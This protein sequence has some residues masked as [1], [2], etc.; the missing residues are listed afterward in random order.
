MIFKIC[1]LKNKESVI[2]CEKN[3]VDLFGMIF[4]EKSPRNISFKQA[5][6]LVNL[7]SDLKIKPVGV[8]V[9]HNINDLKKII[10][11]LD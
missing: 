10:L 7:S 6:N 5:E 8:F 3:N 11:S 9:N 4:Y 1:G 2:C